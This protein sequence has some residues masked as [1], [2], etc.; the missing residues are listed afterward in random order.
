MLTDVGKKSRCRSF[1]S[2]SKAWKLNWGI[3]SIKKEYDF[4]KQN[5]FCHEAT[6]EIIQAK[7]TWA[8]IQVR[9]SNLY[10]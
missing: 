7:I 1:K 4:D 6:H 9:V 2:C 3:V 5:L 10:T 8:P